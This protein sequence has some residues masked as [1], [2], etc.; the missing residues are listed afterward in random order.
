M[1]SAQLLIQ[2]LDKKLEAVYDNPRHLRE[3]SNC[4]FASAM[5]EG[6]NLGSF[7]DDVE[8][9]TAFDLGGFTGA[10]SGNFLDFIKPEYRVMAQPLIDITAGGNG[11]MASI[12]RG[13]F[14][15]SF[16]SD[17]EVLV[18]KAGNGDL[19][20]PDRNEECKHNG[21]KL[22]IE[23]KAGNEIQRTFKMLV[24]G[25]NIQLLKKNYLPV[26]KTDSSLY[27]SEHK[28]RLNGLYWQAMTGESAD[29]MSD[30]QWKIQSLKRAFKRLWQKVD[31]LFIMK[32][33]ND[34]VRF[35]TAKSA[36]EFY[37]SRLNNIEFELRADQAN[38]P[39]FYVGKQEI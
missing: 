26:R 5:R 31:S 29:P 12:G 36:F 39:S 19:R 32:E 17:F 2:R 15:I 16:L 4:V 6:I 33:N 13:E 34:F 35:F 18:T 3:A 23:D 1:N 14:A 27:S 37:S 28:K 25:K 38:A 7:L 10:T 21:G 8:N 30:E 22:A 20:Y 11:G 9:K 24:E